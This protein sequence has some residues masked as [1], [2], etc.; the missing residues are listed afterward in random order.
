VDW[1]HLAQKLYSKTHYGRKDKGG[2]EVTERQG[3]R[4]K[5]LLDDFTVRRQYWELK[6]KAL[7]STLWRTRFGRAY[8]SVVRQ[9]TKQMS[10]MFKSHKLLEVFV[11]F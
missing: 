3:G 7:H 4:C 8:G 1:S 2:T 11:I 10:D 9:T 5:Q 6:K